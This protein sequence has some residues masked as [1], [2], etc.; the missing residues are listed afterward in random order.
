M[1]DLTT[2]TACHGQKN[3]TYDEWK[4]GQ[5]ITVTKK[6]TLCKGTGKVKL[7]PRK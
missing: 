3:V 7:Q 5:K 2:C 4:N 6:C 1:S